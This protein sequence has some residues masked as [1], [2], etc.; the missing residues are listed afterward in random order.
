ME[1]KSWPRA[2]LYIGVKRPDIPH[3]WPRMMAHCHAH[4]VGQDTIFPRQKVYGTVVLYTIPTAHVAQ[5]IMTL[6][7][8]CGVALAF[9]NT[10]NSPSGAVSQSAKSHAVNGVCSPLFET[11]SRHQAS[12]A[13][14]IFPTPLE[15]LLF[16]YINFPAPVTFMRASSS[17]ERDEM[18]SGSSNRSSIHFFPRRDAQLAPVWLLIE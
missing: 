10:E 16:Y 5:S 13:S 11:F 12:T 9:P 1:R 2:L 7:T 14:F 6:H 18:L 8:Y 4:W 3:H 17:R 15:Q